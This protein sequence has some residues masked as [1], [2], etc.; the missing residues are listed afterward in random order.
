M[1]Q[2][3]IVAFV[4]AELPRTTVVVA[5]EENGAPEVSWGSTFFFYDSD[6]DESARRFP[7][8]TIVVADVPG[9][10]ESSRLD[11]EGVFRVN[12]WV[13]REAAEVATTSAPD[14]LDVV[15]RHPVY[16]PQ[17]W[18]SVLNPE[19]TSRIVC[20]LLAEAH[21][22]AARRGRGRSQTADSL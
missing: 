9:F 7:F 19:T 21:Q 12:I 10:D 20:E 15:V 17:G 22:R 18:V 6:G 5:S 13:G 8:A 11:R 4:T 1:T 14:T 16:G 3:E 2:A